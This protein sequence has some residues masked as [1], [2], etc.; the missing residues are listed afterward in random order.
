VINGL[1]AKLRWTDPCS[2]TSGTS[3]DGQS[4]KAAE[5]QSC[6]PRIVQLE[7][8]CLVREHDCLNA[9][10]E[11]ELLKDVRDVRLDGGLADEELVPDFGVR[12]AASYQ[13]KDLSFA[14]AL[15]H[16]FAGDGIVPMFK[17]LIVC[18][19]AGLAWQ[20]LLVAFL[21]GREQRTLRWSTV[22]EALW[23]RARVARAANGSAAGSG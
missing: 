10:T 19:T 4:K 11:I 1:R 18:L 15:A 9:V 2:C 13:A 7:E 22:R 17:A 6:R 8:P 3:G 14:P 12:E 20:F 21:V 16:Q 5:Y 23:L